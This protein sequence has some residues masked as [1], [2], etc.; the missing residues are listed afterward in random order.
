MQE[1]VSKRFFGHKGSGEITPHLDYCRPILEVLVE[2][3]GSGRT[4]DV[5]ARVGERMKPVL[6]PKDY[7][8]HESDAKQIRWCNTA[9]WARNLMANKDGRMKKD[10][11]RGVWEI[12]TAG[13]AWLKKQRG[14]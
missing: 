2:M 11:P 13:Q 3:A 1:I 8:A 10:S 9:Q 7:E 4:K 6:K 14:V 5:L 12:S